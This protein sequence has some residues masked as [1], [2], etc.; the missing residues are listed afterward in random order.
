MK[1]SNGRYTG[2]MTLT[3]AQWV[4]LHLALKTV[5]DMSPNFCS[6]IFCEINEKLESELERLNQQ[7][8]ESV[9]DEIRREE[10]K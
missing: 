2:I 3:E 5:M 4:L 1:L 9:F 6:R 7:H 10:E 8:I